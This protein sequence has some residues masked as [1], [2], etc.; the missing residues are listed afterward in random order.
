MKRNHLLQ[1]WQDKRPPKHNLPDLH[2]VKPPA[3]TDIN[4]YAVFLD[5]D[6]TLADIADHPDRVTI[7][8]KIVAALA[9]LSTR[10]HGALAIISGRPLDTIDDLLGPHKF[11]AA[12]EHGAM[13]RNGN[14][15]HRANTV[16]PQQLNALESEVRD[17][18]GKYE[19]I[20]IERKSSSIAIHYRGC[21]D[22]K[23][24]C[25]AIA[26]R[27]LHKNEG[28]RRMPGK[29]VIELLASDFDKGR[30]IKEFL[31]EPPFLTRI[32]IFA[33]DDVTDEAGFAVTNDHGGLSIKVGSGPSIAKYRINSPTELGTW[34][35]EL[36]A[37]GT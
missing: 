20:L 14:G 24:A 12:G 28:L 21:P 29:M 9:R 23:D 8:P 26:T 11:A 37:S 1:I 33:G 19:G 3:L 15:H 34:L 27:L 4:R 30:A 7:E 13:R 22:L 16:S 25:E 5:L 31:A 2:H 18:L 17:E 35:T 32:P 6:G 36:A 10:L